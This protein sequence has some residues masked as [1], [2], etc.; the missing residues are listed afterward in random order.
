MVACEGL[1]GVGGGEVGGGVPRLRFRLGAA[2]GGR[3]KG[4]YEHASHRDPTGGWPF[5]CAGLSG[6]GGRRPCGAHDCSPTG[7]PVGSADHPAE[8]ICQ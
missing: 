2:C 3:L 8:G 1:G 5:L 4:Q 7:H 6:L